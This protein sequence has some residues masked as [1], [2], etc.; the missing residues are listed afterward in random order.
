MTNSQIRAAH[1][2][3]LVA[4]LRELQPNGASD[5][6]DIGYDAAF[7]VGAIDAELNRRPVEVVRAAFEK[8]G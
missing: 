3:T 4:R 1:T 2:L 8:E 5:H 6:G 7:E